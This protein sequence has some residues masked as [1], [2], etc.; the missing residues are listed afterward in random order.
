M[1]IENEDNLDLPDE[2]SD[3]DSRSHLTNEKSSDSGNGI[4][5]IFCSGTNLPTQAMQRFAGR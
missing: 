5:T 4:Q 1:P 2:V 3:K